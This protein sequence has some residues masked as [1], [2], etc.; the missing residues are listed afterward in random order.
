MPDM[1]GVVRR[2]PAGIEGGRAPG[3]RDGQ[4]AAGG[5]PDPR[6]GTSSGQFGN[7][8]G[9]PGFHAVRLPRAG[10]A[11]ASGTS[12]LLERVGQGEQPGFAPGRSHKGN[13]HRKITDKTSRNGDRGYPAT[14]AGVDEP[15]K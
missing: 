2:D 8:R 5:V 11:G 13:S 15:N 12:G 10:R 6:L 14:A 1:G 4:L 7:A 9:A 3:R